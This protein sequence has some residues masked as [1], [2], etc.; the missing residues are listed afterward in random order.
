MYEVGLPACAEANDGNIPQPPLQLVDR[1]D[2][3]LSLRHL[4]PSCVIGRVGF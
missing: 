1:R 3:D 2:R 4:R